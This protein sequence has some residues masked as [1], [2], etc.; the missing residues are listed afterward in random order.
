FCVRHGR[1][2]AVMGVAERIASYTQQGTRIA[3]VD[4]SR[5]GLGQEPVSAIEIIQAYHE[6]RLTQT[7]SLAEAVPGIKRT[8]RTH[9]EKKWLLARN[10][11]RLQPITRRILRRS[12][13]SGS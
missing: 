5:G 3:W 4:S 2:Y 10:C 9:Q 12:R 6:P 7:K 13:W 11:S 8:L 1:G